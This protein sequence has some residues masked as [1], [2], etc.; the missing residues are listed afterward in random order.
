MEDGGKEHKIDRRWKRNKSRERT[1]RELYKER[2]GER[3]KGTRRVRETRDA[4]E[5]GSEGRW[6][7]R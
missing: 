4:M 5:R 6:Q 2:D 7:G 1:E 3:K